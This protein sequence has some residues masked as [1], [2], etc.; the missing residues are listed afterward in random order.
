MPLP[1]TF[2][3]TPQNLMWGSASN[4]RAY[5]SVY[6]T[7]T[8][9]DP[10]RNFNI[11]YSEDK[12]YYHDMGAADPALDYRYVSNLREVPFISMFYDLSVFGEHKELALI[13]SFEAITTARLLIY[14]GNGLL[15]EEIL[16]IGDNQFLIEVETLDPLYLYFIHARNE[17]SVNGGSW[18]FKGITGY[19]V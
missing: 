3:L 18:F 17:S 6:G 2:T 7:S 19:V 10:T 16:N 15:D 12:L 11:Q 4:Q 9:P 13:F 8:I 5:A 14:T 1:E